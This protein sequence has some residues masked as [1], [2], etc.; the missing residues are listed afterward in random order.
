MF[1][2]HES[3]VDPVRCEWINLFSSGHPGES[4]PGAMPL[5]L[6]TS[7]FLIQVQRKI[8]DYPSREAALALIREHIGKSHIHGCDRGFTRWVIVAQNGMAA[9]WPPQEGAAAM[10]AGSIV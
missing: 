10:S 2:A 6:G 8:G 9:T 3:D 5:T 4:L 1:L 7:T